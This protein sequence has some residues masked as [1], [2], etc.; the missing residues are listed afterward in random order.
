MTPATRKSVLESWRLEIRV[1]ETKTK[2]EG[3]D[4]WYLMSGED[5][6][7]GQ[8][9]WAPAPKMIGQ[10]LSAGPASKDVITHGEDHGP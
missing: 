8:E 6:L 5:R 3:Q 7:E 4:V 1:T 2:I 9:K 10:D